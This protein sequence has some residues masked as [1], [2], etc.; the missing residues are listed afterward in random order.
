MDNHD[1]ASMIAWLAVAAMLFI[2][3]FTLPL[4][5]ETTPTD[6]AF[7]EHPKGIVFPCLP[8]IDA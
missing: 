7:S 5:G 6:A 3:A 4:A 8:E 1:F 2:L